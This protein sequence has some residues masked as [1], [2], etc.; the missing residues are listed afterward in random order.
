MKYKQIKKQLNNCKYWADTRKKED[1]KDRAEQFLFNADLLAEFYLDLAEYR[2]P[3]RINHE[4]DP[5]FKEF[6]KIREKVMEAQR[7]R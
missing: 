3:K 1:Y 4:R 5:L 7:Y 6:E 2:K